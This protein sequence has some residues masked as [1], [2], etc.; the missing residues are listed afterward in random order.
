[1]QPVSGAFNP[2]PD[3]ARALLRVK[4]GLV[5]VAAAGDASPSASG[6]NPAASQIGQLTNGAQGMETKYGTLEHNHFVLDGTMAMFP[7]HIAGHQ[8]G[9]WSAQ[10]SGNDGTFASP[11]TL[12]FTFSKPH[13]SIGF[14]V[15]FDDQAG[16]YCTDF[17]VQAYSASGALLTRADVTGNGLANCPVTLNTDDYSKVV[18]TFL[19]TNIPERYVR[20]SQVLFG[21]IQHQD[22]RNTESAT[23]VYEISPAMEAAPANEFAITIDN[24]DHRYNMVN[25]NGLYR[26]LQ[27]G[28]AL[29]VEMGIGTQDAEEYVNMGR[30]YFT[31]S[32]AL[33]SGLTAQITADNPFYAMDKTTYRKGRVQTMAAKAFIAE[34]FQDAGFPLTVRDVGGVGS[35]MILA[36][37]DLVSHRKAVQLAAQAARCMC[38]VNRDNE[39]VLVEPTIG[40]PTDTVT[41]DQQMDMPAIDIP[42]RVNTVELRVRRLV[43]GG[44]A[45][46]LHEST[47]TVSGTVTRWFTYKSIA[48]GVSASVSGGTL[49]SAS[50]YLGAAQLTITAAGSVTV[51]ITGTPYDRNDVTFTAQQLDTD[52]SEQAKKV[53]NAMV[54]EGSEQQVADW[55]L[56][57]KR[58]VYSY[59]VSDRSNPAREVGDSVRI[60]DAY[61]EHRTA[62][63]T[64]MQI[65]FD[66]GFT[67]TMDAIGKV[68]NE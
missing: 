2:Y 7:D 3:M 57:L 43:A 28:Q 59:T 38:I 48:S 39:V 44:N 35:R 64:K 67:G 54:A 60:Y 5:D 49:V 36:A 30:F 53:D 46:T 33:D 45:D 34:V 63:A 9:W 8:T 32:K 24:A 20:V 26:F 23:L 37:C 40:A 66:K 61:G 56:S 19:R 51:Q 41:L 4:F 18:F 15:V 55:I 68:D 25:P 10:M 31:R 17:T 6:Q 58:G 65:K 14:T 52:E 42:D 13:T 16:Q 29:D 50:Y 27:Q 47:F 12:T 1:M 62:L 11:P 22:N 21:I